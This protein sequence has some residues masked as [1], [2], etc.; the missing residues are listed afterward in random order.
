MFT[1]LAVSDTVTV[2]V[3]RG[4]WGH[5]PLFTTW[6]DSYGQARVRRVGESPNTWKHHKFSESGRRLRLRTPWQS[7]RSCSAKRP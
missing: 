1:P 4:Y 7:S 2:T 3:T 5:G 6:D